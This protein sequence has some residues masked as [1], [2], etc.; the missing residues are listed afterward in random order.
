MRQA[1]ET[2]MEIVTNV[3]GV[4]TIIS[5]ITQAPTSRPVRF[6][7]FKRL[8]RAFY[9]PKSSPPSNVTGS[10]C[11]CDRKSS[12]RAWVQAVNLR[13]SAAR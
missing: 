13:G 8:S 12:S 7:S 11:V 3:A 9:D 5:E 1:G 10:P 4:T 6:R 2:M